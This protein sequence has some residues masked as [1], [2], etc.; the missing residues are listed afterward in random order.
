M[1]PS[2]GIDW[3]SVHDLGV[4]SDLDIAARLDVWPSTVQRVRRV[5][6]IP[7][8]VKAK[9][10]DWSGVDWSKST[11]A[12]ARKLGCSTG[13]VRGE[14]KR[15]GVTEY[16]RERPSNANPFK[17]VMRESTVYALRRVDVLIAEGKCP[18][19]AYM[20]AGA[21]L[22]VPW[23]TVQTAHRRERARGKV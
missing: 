10:V 20:Q 16:V 12:I 13:A 8:P 2:K 21:E 19:R 15:L 18:Q 5:R 17:K 11:P 14:R 22:G 6:G 9:R 1:A 23:R 4:A 3:A 7:A